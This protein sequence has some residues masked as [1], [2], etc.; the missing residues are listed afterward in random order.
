MAVVGYGLGNA[1]AF[2]THMLHHHH[3]RHPIAADDGECGVLV[4][5]SAAL[6]VALCAPTR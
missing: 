1:Q 6:P 5:C 3:R 2:A 4:Y